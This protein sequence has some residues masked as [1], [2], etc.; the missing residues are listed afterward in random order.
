[1]PT[2]TLPPEMI[3]AKICIA[4]GSLTKLAELNGLHKSTISAALKRPQNKGN[5]AIADCLNTTVHA[6]WPQWFDASGN[7]IL[8]QKQ[9][10]SLLAKHTSQKAPRNSDKEAA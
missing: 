10:S 8:T 1:M 7:R 3:K 4:V 9:P 6:L 5:H 2:E